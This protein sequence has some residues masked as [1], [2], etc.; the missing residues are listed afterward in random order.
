MV[1]TQAAVVL[2]VA[3]ALPSAVWLGV[4]IVRRVKKPDGEDSLPATMADT[5]L[6]D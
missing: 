5:F 3:L 2:A 6:D 4:R 1:W